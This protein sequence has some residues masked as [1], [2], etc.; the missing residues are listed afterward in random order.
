M[1]CNRCGKENRDG[2]N[3]CYACGQPLGQFQNPGF[4]NP[5]YCNPPYQSYQYGSPAQLVEHKDTVVAFLLALILPGVG[6]LYAGEVKKGIVI[7]AF[8]IIV[9]IAAIVAFVGMFMT[10]GMGGDTSSATGL[11]IVVLIISV[12][13]WLYQVYDAYQAALRFNVAH[14]LR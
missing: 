8:F 12:V 4:A 2:V 9:G 11:I 3:F 14:G 6:H 10:F 1:Y 5:G 7:L 13:I